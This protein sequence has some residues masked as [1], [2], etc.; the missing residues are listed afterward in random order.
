M[1]YFRASRRV[2]CTEASPYLNHI[3]IFYIAA[4]QKALLAGIKH[5]RK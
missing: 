1:V 3:T 2:V 5:G 4:V